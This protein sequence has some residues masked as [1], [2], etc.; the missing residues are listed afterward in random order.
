MLS[1]R[2]DIDELTLTAL[3]ETARGRY[4]DYL[5]DERYRQRRRERP[6]ASKDALR[7]AATLEVT[8][9]LQTSLEHWFGVDRAAFLEWARGLE[10]MTNDDLDS[11]S[12]QTEQ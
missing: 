1:D 4:V 7:N 11:D 9:D 5:I 10:L 2:T 8:G 12:E 6:G 3:K